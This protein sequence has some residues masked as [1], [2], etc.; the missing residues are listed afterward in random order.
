[1]NVFAVEAYAASWIEILP[2]VAVVAAIAVEAYAA[3]WIEIVG[4][5]RKALTPKSRLTQPRGLK[6]HNA[7]KFLPYELSRLTQPRGLK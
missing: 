6:C 5:A 1:M 2:V 4:T 3:S 7:V